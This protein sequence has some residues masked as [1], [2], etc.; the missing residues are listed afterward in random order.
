MHIHHVQFDTELSD[1][2]VTG[3]SYRLAIRP[4]V[5]EDPTLTQPATQGQK[6]VHVSSAAK[7]D[8]GAWI[9]VGMGLESIEI[10]QIDGI[11]TAN[12]TLTLAKPLDRDHATSEA[13]GVEFLQSRW[14]PDVELDN[15]FWHD[16]VDGIH[17]WGQGLVGQLIVEPKG[18]TYHDPRPGAQVESGTFVDIHTTQAMA[19]GKV[20]G[21][22]RELA[23]WTIDTNPVT[24]STLNLR[25]E[26]FADRLRT[27]GDPSLLF[28]SWTHGDPVTP[29]PMAYRGDPFVIR[30]VNVGDAE[31]TLHVDGHRFL[32]DPRQTDEQGKS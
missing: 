20:D 30:T 9:A 10:R 23:L 11:D 17:T 1:G 5:A 31:D 27:N 16:H 28:S 29:V 8:P 19:P 2:P 18:S 3:L 7:F 22:F 12:N 25:A 13:A 26:P 4:L 21:S 15:V 24:D 32:I 6:F 14:Y